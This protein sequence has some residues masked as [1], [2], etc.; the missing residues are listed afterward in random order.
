MQEN[1]PNTTL[2]DARVDSVEQALDALVNA[3]PKSGEKIYTFV[4][5]C[6]SVVSGNEQ[7]GL[8]YSAIIASLVDLG[9]KATDPAA[10]AQLSLNTAA[11]EEEKAVNA[12][13]AT[14][15]GAA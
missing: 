6:V 11:S 14:E 8:L 13:V 3:K 12:V 2:E 10:F 15:G 9:L 7:R 5:R 4:R 1:I